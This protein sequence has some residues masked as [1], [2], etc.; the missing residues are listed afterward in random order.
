MFS[1][2]ILA[3]L[4]LKDPVAHCHIKNSWINIL[5][6]T[7]KYVYYIYTL[8]NEAEHIWHI[9]TNPNDQAFTHGSLSD[10]ASN[11]IGSST[12]LR[13]G[14]LS[15]ETIWLRTVWCAQTTLHSS[16]HRNT[17]IYQLKAKAPHYDYEPEWSATAHASG[18]SPRLDTACQDMPQAGNSIWKQHQHGHIDGWV[19]WWISIDEISMEY[20]YIYIYNDISTSSPFLF[21]NIIN[22]PMFFSISP[23][24]R[25]PSH[26]SSSFAMELWRS[27]FSKAFRSGSTSATLLLIILIFSWC[28]DGMVRPSQKWLN[29]M[30]RIVKMYKRIEHG[31]P[32]LVSGFGWKIWCP[33]ENQQDCWD[34][35][36]R[37]YA[38]QNFSHFVPTTHDSAV[39]YLDS[40]GS[41]SHGTAMCSI[42]CLIF[43]IS[44]RGEKAWC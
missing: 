11:H 12:L 24:S 34:L 23:A 32:I 9:K 31:D 10:S 6:Y 21:L 20:V 28:G 33:H 14:H 36:P 13:T 29:G 39:F 27:V 2:I 41:Y 38:R 37:T 44:W 15:L 7:H 26:T 16:I 25:W 22:I 4:N 18:C 3:A 42:F 8:P 19:T 40:C 35:K 30:Q 17:T 43:W 5:T 1:W